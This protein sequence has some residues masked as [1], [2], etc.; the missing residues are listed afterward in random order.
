MDAEFWRERW[1]SNQ[2]G[3]HKAEANPLLVAHFSALGLAPGAR[4]FLPLCG[5]TKDIGWLLAQGCEVA[6]AELSE[7]AVAQL[8]A[9]LDIEPSLT[10]VGALT[11]YSARDID[12]FVGDIFD[13]EAETLGPVDAVYDRAALVALPET[14][15]ARYAAHLAA[16]T[17]GAPQLLIC[18]EYDQNAVDGPPF[19]IDA[20]EVERVHRPCYDLTP[21]A[22]IDVE[23]GLKGTVPADETVWLL[24]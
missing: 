9:D 24:R 4:V 12:V 11:R 10:K 15:R 17:G 19:S 14:M 13:L 2:I 8:F 5:K 21:V 18:F 20:A 1:R 16:M 3:F 7:I 6:G 23:G 22:K